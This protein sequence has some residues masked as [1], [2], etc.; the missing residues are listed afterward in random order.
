MQRKRTQNAAPPHCSPGAAGGSVNPA[1]R[2]SWAPRRLLPSLAASLPPSP[3]R[4]FP[5][6]YLLPSLWGTP[7]TPRGLQQPPGPCRRPPGPQEGGPGLPAHTAR[8][9]PDTAAPA[10]RRLGAGRG[11]PPPRRRPP[12]VPEDFLRNAPTLKGGRRAAAEAALRVPPAGACGI[13]AAGS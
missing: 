7:A 3:P 13:G 9:S 11:Q 4:S 2:A 1:P 6:C 10:P 8:S 5:T 12:E